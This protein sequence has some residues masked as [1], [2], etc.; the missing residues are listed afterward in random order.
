MIKKA[1]HIL[2][3]F[4]L[5]GLI[6]L[7]AQAQS[8][9]T[10]TRDLTTKDG[11]SHNQTLCTQQD[12]MGFI[13]IGTKY[14]LNRYDGHEFRWFTKEKNGLS[15]NE[16]NQIYTDHQGRLWL[17]NWEELHGTYTF[18]S[19]DLFDP[20]SHQV[21]SFSDFF[22]ENS[23][24][25]LEDIRSIHSMEDNRLIFSTEDGL[26]FLFSAE[27]KFEKLPLPSDFS[28]HYAVDDDELWGSRGGSLIR[29]NK[30]GRI[31][32][33]FPLEAGQV[34]RKVTCDGWN[35]Y[36]VVIEQKLPGL[37]YENAQIN[38]LEGDTL[39]PAFGDNKSYDSRDTRILPLK[40]SKKVLLARGKIIVQFGEGLDQPLFRDSTT[41][42]ENP[43]H[44]KDNLF[45][46][47][48]GLIWHA[49][50]DG[51]TMI[52]IRLSP[53]QQY[54]RDEEVGEFST[55]GLAEYDGKLFVN[56]NSLFHHSGYYDLN[57][58]IW[59][60]YSKSY[61][62]FDGFKAFP[63]YLTPEGELW[64][65]NDHLYRFDHNGSL[66]TELGKRGKLGGRIWA[67]FRDASNTWWIGGR[68]MYFF[69]ENQHDT[70]LP[71]DRYNGF[72]ELKKTDPWH[73]LEDEHGIWIASSKGLYLLKK[74]NG[75]VARYGEQADPPFQI[76][77]AQF[78][79][80]YKDKDGDLW[81]ATGNAGLIK[82]ALDEEGKPVVKRHLT[83]ADG[84][85]SNELYAIFEDEYDHLWISSGNGLI[86]Y[87]KETGEINVFF[88]EQGITHNEFNRLS[89]FQSKTGRVY[90]GGMN[91]VTAFSPDDF[92]NRPPYDAP[93][94]LSS[95]KLFSGEEER[96]VD[97]TNETCKQRKIN[98]RPGDKFITMKLSLQDYFF[99]EKVKYSYRIQGLSQSWEEL[100]S[101]ALQLS[102]LPYGRHTLEIRA[103]G[104]DNRY[105]TQQL[106]LNINVLRPFFLQSWFLLTFA[107]V[108]AATIWQWYR[109]RIRSYKKRQVLLE[110]LV[111]DRTQKI[112]ED[113]LLIEEQAEQLRELDELK[114][115]FFA[116]IS[117]EL[118]TPLTLIL[119]PLENMLNSKKLDN[120]EFTLMKLM[121]Q[122]GKQ[123]LKRINEL[124]DL[125]S[126]DANKL[127][128]EK[129]PVQLYSY[130]KQ[131]L[132][133]FE[134]GANLKKIRLTLD[135]QLD[136]QVQV[137][138]DADKVEKIITNFLSNAVKFT[139]ENGQISMS[140][141]P[142]KGKLE[143]SI[144]DSGLGI[145]EE[146]IDKVF[147]RFYQAKG[148]DKSTGTGIGLALCRELAQ[149]MEGRVWAESKLGKGSTFFLELPLEESFDQLEP[150]SAPTE[151]EAFALDIPENQ[152]GER[153]LVVE[154]NPSL[155]QYIQFL[156][157]PY[158]VITAENGKVGLEKLEELQQ[159]GQAVNLI[160]SDI[161]M[162]VMDGFALLEAVKNN[163]DFRHIPVIMLTARQNQ[164][165]KLEAL[166]IGVDD[167]MVKPFQETELLAR[168]A[169]LMRNSRER[170]A[171]IRP[172]SIE[173]KVS[174]KPQG[175]AVL[176]AADTKWLKE[177]EQYILDNMGNPQFGISQLAEE[178]ALSPRRFQ[179]KIKELTGLTPK[180][181]Q[182]EIQ[183]EYGRRLLE[184]GDY[185]TVSEVSYEVG[186]KDAH[187]FSTLF[188]KRFGK[189]PNEYL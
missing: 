97:I 145:P 21:T 8:Y 134:S 120:R 92:Y 40:S 66:L 159:S 140:V 62:Q 147:D 68:P 176:T 157:E 182:R 99:S 57:Q 72:D 37:M 69:N 53:F 33:S 34:V 75:I 24:F 152:S 20:F 10:N 91:G 30:E 77:G 106:T 167:Y 171:A 22:Q 7:P 93:I 154:D 79:Y 15:S 45:V 185:Q 73:F 54:M 153:I 48:K 148:S 181:Y 85:P 55:R 131:L 82:L 186:F 61:S 94:R 70:P 137:L 46:D 16:I 28:L 102:G 111:Q 173:K 177:I 41:L 19:V 71:F 43:L 67:F 9:L 100:Y 114:S 122:N 144:S 161:M 162:P 87:S 74:G 117:H 169:N 128:I 113:K 160:I 76:P 115:R 103:K 42:K 47:R 123:L 58:K 163:D 170:L 183:L 49:H 14:G 110:K 149:L 32:R 83:R 109:W 150:Q 180:T 107:F 2:L 124:L 108:I 59:N 51:L 178:L 187:Y 84:L 44:S 146:E 132:S 139:P 116:N 26:H 60:P 156:L 4:F 138:F 121:Q 165:V 129:S 38:V 101:N 104:P 135:F 98:F 88:E 130:T 133:L 118:R 11:L 86:Q 136:Q 1:L 141:R 189:K 27:E 168:V 155:L 39:R 78:Y 13:W 125:S 172:A 29:V 174:Q 50:R 12:S 143:I 89:Y 23:P 36:W 96:L 6:C 175:K 3:S 112:R 64:T 142:Q 188:F 184:S 95:I 164:E 127:N 90:F 80:I 18:I 65:A 81:L 31:K 166:R 126:L 35:R 56:T 63:L 119:G 52:D 17:V 179:Q 158:Q 151:A 25:R 105:S 5:T